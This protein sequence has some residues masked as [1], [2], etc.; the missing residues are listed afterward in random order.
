MFLLSKGK[1]KFYLYRSGEAS[2]TKTLEETLFPDTFMITWKRFFMEQQFQEYDLT[3][4]Q[5]NWDRQHIGWQ[6]FFALDYSTYG[7]V[8]TIFD[9]AFIEDEM[10]VEN[11]TLKLQARD[12]DESFIIDVLPVTDEITLRLLYGDD[13]YEGLKLFYKSV[14]TYKTLGFLK[15]LAP[16]VILPGGGT[17]TPFEGQI[18]T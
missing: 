3:N 1:H 17:G 2:G 16:G 4:M 14:K 8:D 9:A 10:T 12:D 5:I 13:A 15:P 18:I 11:M 6:I 7:N